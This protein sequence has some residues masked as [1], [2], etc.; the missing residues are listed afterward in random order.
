DAGKDP[1]VIVGGSVPEWNTNARS[2][3]SKWF[4]IEADEYDYAFLGLAP[5]IA[6][7]TNVDYDHPDLFPTRKA[8]DEAFAKFMEQTRRVIIV[9][10]DDSN[11]RTIA[12]LSDRPVETYGLGEKN[13]W[14]AVDVRVN[15]MG[16]TSFT[17]QKDTQNI[18]E[19]SLKL[20]GKH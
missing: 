20:A 5:E 14:R 15:E 19:V 13:K 16:G 11:A 9:C 8:Y 2:G 7:V 1:S 18:G 3:M 12:N 4:V 10:G 6:V 17:I